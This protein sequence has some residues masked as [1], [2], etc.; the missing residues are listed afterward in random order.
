MSKQTNYAFVDQ[1]NPDK[2]QLFIDAA[3]CSLAKHGYKGTT[4]RKIAE[5]AGV[6]PGL[7]THYFDGKEVLIAE[8]YQ[9]LAQS[10]LNDFRQNIDNSENNPLIVLRSFIENIFRA[11]GLGPEPLRVWLS[12]WTLTLTE[13]DLRSTHQEIY[14]SYIKSIEELLKDAHD[15]SSTPPSMNINSMAI[16]IMSLLDGMWLECCLNPDALSQNKNIE[17]VFDFVES[18]TGLKLKTI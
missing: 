15:Y 1:S 13:P 3:I 12:F 14:K 7:L 17:I 11:D 2:K 10:F 18:T 4:V 8:S 9:Y 5:Y 6:A 16:G